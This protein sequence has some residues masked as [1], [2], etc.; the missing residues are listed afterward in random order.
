V[1]GYDGAAATVREVTGGTGV[2]AVYDGVGRA[3]FDASLASLRRHGVMVSFGNAS[4]TVPAIEPL[5]LPN[6]IFLTRPTLGHFVVAREDLERRA[7]DVFAG[8]AAGRLDV[9]IGGRYPLAEA[10]AAQRDLAARATTGKLLI[11]P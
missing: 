11:V 10:G 7:G 8:I 4:G 1:V 3:T 9:H 6:S 2:A 5:R